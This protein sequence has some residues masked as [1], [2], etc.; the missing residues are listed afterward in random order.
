MQRIFKYPI[1]V[2]DRQTIMLP[3]G[4]VIRASQ[5][6][7]TQLCLWAEVNDKATP[8]PRDIAIYG[9]GHEMPDYPG[10]YIGTFQMNQGQFVFHAYDRGSV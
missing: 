6:Q 1:E 7:G 9:T 10:N 8:V 4:A 2:L 5:W 3:T